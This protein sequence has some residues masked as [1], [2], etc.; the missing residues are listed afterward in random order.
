MGNE[1]AKFGLVMKISKLIMIRRLRI[2]VRNSWKNS[3][4]VFIHFLYIFGKFLF[5]SRT[6]LNYSYAFKDLKFLIV[7]DFVILWVLQHSTRV[8]LHRKMQKL[9]HILLLF[10]TRIYFS[11]CRR[12]RHGGNVEKRK[13][14]QQ[15]QSTVKTIK[16]HQLC[17]NTL[18]SQAIRQSI[19]ISLTFL[20]CCLPISMNL[21]RRHRRPRFKKSATGSHFM[22]GTSTSGP[23]G[24]FNLATGVTTTGVWWHDCGR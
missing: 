24:E 3:K 10:V 13:I 14:N 22:S 7:F 23:T 21:P 9:S 19:N 12:S 4:S 16:T 6:I 11:R 1:L 2:Y 15:S 17:I 5:C 8:L 20:L 18:T